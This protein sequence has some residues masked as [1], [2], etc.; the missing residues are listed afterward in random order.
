MMDIFHLIKHNKYTFYY[1]YNICMSVCEIKGGV[2]ALCALNRDYDGLSCFTL[3]ELIKISK[4]YNEQRGREI[5]KFDSN[6]DMLHPKK[7]K[8]YLVLA[9]T[10]ALGEEQYKWLD[11]V[12]WSEYKNEVYRPD[13]P[14]GP[15]EWLNSEHIENFLEQ[16][17]RKYPD[18]LSFGAVPID[19][20]EVNYN[21]IRNLFNLEKFEQNGKTKIGI[22]Y[23]LDKH[24]QSG[25]HWVASY[26]DLKTGLIS[27]FDSYG[28]RPNKYVRRFLRR[29]VKYLKEKDRP[30]KSEYNA[31]RN[32][33]KNSECGM[34]SLNFIRMLLKGIPFEKIEENPIPDDEIN[35]C[36]KTFFVVHKK[37]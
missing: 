3:D 16:L 1:V 18:F 24:N 28:M 14:S 5:V 25:S 21:N 26:I 17:E 6:L 2:N 30:I 36:R 22:I 23:N 20:W 31:T 10:R 13:G 4:M 7:Y 35:A 19:F 34:Y 29:F 12:G 27:Y 11:Q 9:L 15:R 37:Q 32:Q 8:E 33:F